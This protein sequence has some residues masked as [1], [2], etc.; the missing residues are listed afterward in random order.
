MAAAAAACAGEEDVMDDDDVAKEEDGGCGGTTTGRI[1]PGVVVPTT[2]KSRGSTNVGGVGVG[3]SRSIFLKDTF[4]SWRK[5]S[6]K[7][8]TNITRSYNIPC[9]RDRETCVTTIAISEGTME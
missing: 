1:S 5:R 9:R 7:P 4:S 2:A 8:M 6:T 3:G